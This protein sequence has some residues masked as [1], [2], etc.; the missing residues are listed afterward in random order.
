M[1]QLLS[2][3]YYQ[4][5]VLMKA[6]NKRIYDGHIMTAT[7][8]RSSQADKEGFENLLKYLENSRDAFSKSQENIQEFVR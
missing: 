8:N 3:T 7:L 6:A 4:V 1:E 5:E 2:H